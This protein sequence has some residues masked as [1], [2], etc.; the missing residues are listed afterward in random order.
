MIGFPP[1]KTFDHAATH[2]RPVLR[3]SAEATPPRLPSARP[4][5]FVPMDVLLREMGLAAATPDGR[6]D[7]PLVAPH[8]TDIAEFSPPRP[9]RRPPTRFAAPQGRDDD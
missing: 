5:G 4:E 9:L 3:A 1:K 7:A 8:S 6:S 2:P